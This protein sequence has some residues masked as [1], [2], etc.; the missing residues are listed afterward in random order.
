MTNTAE[1]FEDSSEADVAEQQAPATT[2]SASVTPAP[3]VSKA[4][5]NEA[6]ALEQGAIP[7]EDE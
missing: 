5:A 7:T 2:E 1:P 4:E 3:T 6:D